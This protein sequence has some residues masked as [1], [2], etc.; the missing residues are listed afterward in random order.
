MSAFVLSSLLY[1]G[2]AEAAML[3]YNII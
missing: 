2:H 3:C 1:V